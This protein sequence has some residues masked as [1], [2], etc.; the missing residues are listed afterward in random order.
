MLCVGDEGGCGV[1]V[2]SCWAY[3][4]TL[5]CVVVNGD[6]D[7]FFEFVFDGVEC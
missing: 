2:E 7:V 3:D 6:E 5:A 1:V 4:C